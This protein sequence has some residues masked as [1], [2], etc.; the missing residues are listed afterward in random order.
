M[1][2]FRAEMIL[3]VAPSDNAEEHI[4][5]LAKGREFITHLWAL[6]YNAGIPKQAEGEW[7][8]LASTNKKR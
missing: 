7:H 6:L 5:H 3:Y 1:A 8:P 4:K 2:E